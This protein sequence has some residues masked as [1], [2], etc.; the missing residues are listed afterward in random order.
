MTLL[1]HDPRFLDHDTGDHP[2]C[3]A[4]LTAIVRRL[5]ADGLW[6]AARELRPRDATRAEITAVHD[7]EYVR[8]LEAFA[9][10]GGGALD[11]D[12][13]VA[14]GSYGAAVRAAGA[15]LTAIDEI[16]AGRA[17]SAFCLVRP[18]GHHATPRAGMGFCLFNNVA[19]GA[20]YLLDRKLAE[21]VL[22]VDWDVHHGNGTQDAFYAAPQVLYFSTHRYPF[23]PG[24][25]ARTEQGAGAGLGFTINRP[26]AAGAGR[27]EFL[28]VFTEVLRGPAREFRPEWLLISAGFDAHRADP[29]GSFCLESADYGTLTR[30]VTELARACARGRVVSALE[31]GYDLEALAESAAAHVA[32]LAEAEAE[33]KG[34]GPGA[35]G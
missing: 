33:A 17:T 5:R 16:A 8:A 2:E 11:A 26:L 34:P 23:Y 25:G 24:S 6:A 18:P 22:I 21:R 32:A 13:W 15:V 12:T 1:I 19:I 4:R 35:G 28:R 20:R 10:A 29:L 30:E 14:P 9:A 3:A 31:G 27:A 7:P